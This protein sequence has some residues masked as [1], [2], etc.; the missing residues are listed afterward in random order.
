M[1]VLPAHESALPHAR[2]VGWMPVY[3][4]TAAL[5][6]CCA[7]VRAAIVQV[8]GGLGTLILGHGGFLVV[9]VSIVIALGPIA[10]S[11][12]ALAWP[13]GAGLYWRVSSGGRQPSA[14]ERAAFDEA[15]AELKLYR[16]D[17]R[18][19][20]SWFVLDQPDV[21][22]AA[23]GNTIMVARPALERDG[24]TA[25]LAHELGHIHSWDSRVTAAINRFAFLP[26]RRAARQFEVPVD[27]VFMMARASGAI[28]GQLAYYVWFVASGAFGLWVTMPL[29]SAYFRRRE[30][31]ADHYAYLLGQGPQLAA[32]MD[33]E[34]LMFDRPV[35]F[36][37]MNSANS[38]PPT[39]LR[40]DRLNSYV[41]A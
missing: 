22:A 19:P 35:P 10:L 4:L 29:W 2:E 38:H 12:L 37:F 8:I 7:F 6:L 23:L 34:F 18:P 31:A 20:G 33:D 17:V 27:T 32:L 15:I 5:E 14:R 30:Y 25:L 24:L 36:A 21:N 40:I 16:P 11:V 28:L 39:E 3:A 13:A 9:P 41:D 26:G 1:T